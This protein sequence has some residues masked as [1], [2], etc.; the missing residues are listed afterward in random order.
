MKEIKSEIL[1]LNIK[2]SST[3][4]SIPAIILKQCVDILFLTNAI[5]KTFLDN[6]FPKELKKV[7]IIP[8]NKKD[9]PLKKENYRPVSLLPHVSK[10]FESLIYNQINDYMCDKLSKYITGFR[11]CHGAKHLLLVMLEKWKKALDNGENV[12]TIFMDLSKAFDSI[13]HDL[14]LAK[15][16]AYGFS[17]NALKLMCSYS[18]DRRQAVQT[19]NNLVRIRKFKLV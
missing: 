11:K 16:K 8:V 7:E 19:N 9:H 15:L 5:N 6:Y 12:F 1:N 13:N 18:K 4:G 3:K 14:L 10:I 2:K 17:E